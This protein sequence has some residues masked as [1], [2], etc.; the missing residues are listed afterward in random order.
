MLL[1]SCIYHARGT[2]S[3]PPEWLQFRERGQQLARAIP[4]DALVIGR[5]AVLYAADRRGMR[6]ER[7]PE[8][9]RRARGE[10]GPTAFQPEATPSGL[11]SWYHGQGARYYAE[12]ADPRGVTPEFPGD[13]RSVERVIYQGPGLLLLQLTEPDQ[14]ADN[15]G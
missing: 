12:M 9:I 8:A 4:Q 14:H 15:E 1:S 7:D 6:M 11:V 2:W 13:P 3:T 10:W 5:E